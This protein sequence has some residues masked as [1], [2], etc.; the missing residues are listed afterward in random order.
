MAFDF[1]NSPSVGQRVTGVGGI[2]YVWDGVKWASNIGSVTAQS[3]GDVG[4]NLLHNPLFNVAQRGAGPW[5]TPGYTLDQWRFD[6]SLDTVTVSAGLLL[7]A[8][9]AAIGDEEALN[10]LSA[11]VTGNAG[12]SSYSFISQPIENVRRL[13]GKTVTVSFWAWTTSGTPKIGV[14]LRQYFGTGGSP[15]A[16]VDLNA[17]PVTL[18]TGQVRY[19]ATITLPSI[20]GKTLGTNSDHYTRLAFWLSSGANTNVAAGGIGVQSATFV[21]WGV[22]L[23]IGSVATPLE[24]P[25]PRYDLENARR[26]YQT[27]SI[28]IGGNAVVGTVLQHSFRFAPVMRA[29]PTMTFANAGSANIGTIAG[30]ASSTD[31]GNVSTGSIPAAG[32]SY[33]ALTAIASAD[34]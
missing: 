3:M 4:R 8:H 9:R 25:D 21:L 33:L 12:A 20:S 18:S 16:L 31:S 15:S 30:G 10:Y 34:L 29:P 24:K 17:T 13:A 6:Y 5:T 22:Q 11:A 26:F 19:T 14:G 7:D 1:P 23:E 27:F 28:N 32:Q 2:V